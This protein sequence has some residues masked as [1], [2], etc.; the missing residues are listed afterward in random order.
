[1]KPHYNKM[2]M[3][4]SLNVERLFPKNPAKAMGFKRLAVAVLNGRKPLDSLIAALNDA[5]EQSLSSKY[6]R[7]LQGILPQQ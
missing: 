5:D 1:M 7:R 2:I 4:L 6:V 3:E